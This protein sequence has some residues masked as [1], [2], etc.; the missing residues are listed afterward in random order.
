MWSYFVTFDL[1]S[2]SVVDLRYRSNILC[3]SWVALVQNGNYI[4]MAML[5]TDQ[6]L[7]LFDTVIYSFSVYKSSYTLMWGWIDPIY[8][9]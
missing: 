9:R 2:G 4:V 3:S 8:G 6:Y 1:N 5:W 7:V